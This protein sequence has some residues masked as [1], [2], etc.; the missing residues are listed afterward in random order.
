[1]PKTNSIFFTISLVFAIAGFSILI[2]FY[3]LHQANTMQHQSFLERKHFA[4]SRILI[5]AHNEDMISKDLLSSLDSLNYKLKTDLQQIADFLQ[6]ED[7]VLLHSKDLQ[8]GQSV[9]IYQMRNHHYILVNSSGSL[10]LLKDKTPVVFFNPAIIII[11]LAIMAV[12]ILIYLTTVRKLYPIKTLKNHIKKLGNESFDIKYNIKGSDEISELA[13]EFAKSSK[14]LE[15]LKESRNIFI[16]NIMHELKTPIMKG[17][18]LNELPKTEDNNEKMKE[19]FY[20][21]E[22]LINEFASIEE[23]IAA[24]ESITMKSYSIAD[25]IDNAKD[26]LLYDEDSERIVVQNASAC[27]QNVT[28]NF[29]L[30]SIAFKNLLDNAMKYAEDKKVT[31]VCRTDAVSFQNRAKPLSEDLQTY[32]EPFVKDAKQNSSSFG[33]GLYIV[34]KILEVHGFDLAYTHE[35]GYNIFTVRFTDR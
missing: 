26:M 1:M 15:K 28:L 18:L 10:Y 33:L 30:A 23:V 9:N 35:Q 3:F 8:N 7:V 32:F 16:R 20:R 13:Q 14:R 5:R 31:I 21:L 25:V 22:N 11:F 29:K 27:T 19:V 34:K 6:D 2:S 24:S 12:F 4:V 17:K